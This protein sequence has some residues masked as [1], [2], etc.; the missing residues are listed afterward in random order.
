MLAIAL[1]PSKRPPRSVTDY[2]GVVDDYVGRI[3]NAQRKNW[4]SVHVE[5]SLHPSLPMPFDRT[6]K[7]EAPFLSGQEV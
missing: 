4:L 7:A 1:G 2:P 3:E 5:D 6:R